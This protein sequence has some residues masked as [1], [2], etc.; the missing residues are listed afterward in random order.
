MTA[1]AVAV[2]A[3]GNVVVAGAFAGTVDLGGGPLTAQGAAANVFVASFDCGGALRWSKAFGVPTQAND[4]VAA[5]AVDAAGNIL[6]AGQFEGTIDFGA[7]PLTSLKTDGFVAKLSPAGDGL[8]SKRYGD[9]KS[10]DLAS[11]IAADAAGNVIVTGIFE[12]TVDFG[13]GAIHGDGH[14]LFLLAL[15]PVR[16]PPLEQ[17]NRAAR[18]LAQRRGRSAGAG[19]DVRRGGR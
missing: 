18:G 1:T 19:A 14:D 16:Q 6:V 9:V 3:S 5:V 7:G 13:G 12:G 2:D 8:W 4:A 11:G 10:Q 17:G 15:D